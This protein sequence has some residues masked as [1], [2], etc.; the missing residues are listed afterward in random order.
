M[1][2]VK[3]NMQL[4]NLNLFS[5]EQIPYKGLLKVRVIPPQNLRHPVLPIR[6]KVY[7]IKITRFFLNKIYLRT[8]PVFYSHYVYRVQLNM[9]K[10]RPALTITFVPIQTLNERLPIQDLIL[11]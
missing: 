4:K 5:P 10:N 7:N 6:I 9:K 8:I 1:D 2:Q 11:S 3:E